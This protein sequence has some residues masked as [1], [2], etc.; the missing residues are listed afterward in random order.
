MTSFAAP[1]VSARPSGRSIPGIAAVA[2]VCDRMSRPLWLGP[3]G[4]PGPGSMK[5]NTALGLILLGIA[6]WSIAV[7]PG[8]AVARWIGLSAAAAALIGILTLVEYLIDRDLWIDH[9]LFARVGR[10]GANSAFGLA[11]LGS[12]LLAIGLGARRQIAEMCAVLAGAVALTA[13]IGYLYG[14]MPLTRLTAAATQMA[15]STALLFLVLSAGILRAVPGGWMARVLTS[16]GP[17]SFASRRLLPV[18]FGALI[19]LGWLR[20]KGQEAG[21]YGTEFGLSIMVLA[22]I[23]VLT[24]AILW[25]AESLDRAEA[26]RRREEDWRLAA[27]ARF[28][29]MQE[30]DR[31]KSQFLADM[32]HELRTPLNAIIGFTELIHDGK[33]GPASSKYKEYLSDVL[34]SANHLLMLINEVLDLAKVESGKLELRPQ[35]LALDRLATEVENGL[36]GLSARKQISIATDID[37]ALNDLFLDASRLKQVLYNFLSNALKFTPPEGK[38]TLRARPEGPGFFRLE[39]EDTG[40]GIREEDLPRLFQEFQQVHTKGAT[41]EPG[42]G[43]GLALTRRIV[44]AQ[45]GQVGVRSSFGEGSV[46]YAVLPRHAGIL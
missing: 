21:L 3:R 31:L 19:V 32:S 38:V 18:I 23:A 4:F 39:V 12:G 13:L 26:A 34:A 9:L 17:G 11:A 42:T 30:A 10:M 2:A 8:G 6:L 5:P 46:F 40:I 1:G 41:D 35:P 28:A 16:D 29:A 25:S 24:G 36:R 45:G 44:E 20:L 27:E 7:R 22:T 43:L 37:P 14:V 15:F 33:V